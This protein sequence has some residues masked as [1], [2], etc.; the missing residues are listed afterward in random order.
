MKNH[1]NNPEMPLGLGMALA[2]NL[3]AMNLFASMTKEQQ[4]RIIEHTHTINSKQE[5]NAF[6]QSISEFV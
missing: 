4:Q 3:D 5:M 6:V 2:Q 1:V